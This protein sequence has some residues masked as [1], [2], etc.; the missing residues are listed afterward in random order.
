MNIDKAKLYFFSSL[1][2]FYTKNELASLYKFIFEHI[3]NTDFTQILAN[4]ELKINK[5]KLDKIITRLKNYEPYQYII[6]KTE[7][8]DLEFF[9]DK[10]VLIPRPE[11]EELV[12][13]IIDENKSAKQLNILDIGT[14]SGCI[15]VSLVKN[16]NCNFC[17]G[18]DV[19]NEAIKIAKQNAEQNSTQVNFINLNILTAEVKNFNTKFN[20]IVS[21]P[22]YVTD[23]QKKQMQKNVLNHEPHTALFVDDKNPL[24]FYEKIINLSKNILA[25][26]GILYLEINE[27]F[28]SEIKNLLTANKITNSKI[29]KDINNKN[30]IIIAKNN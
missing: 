4:T 8:F 14:G 15:I 2:D 26:N 12:K 24:I 27:N 6:G 5:N 11:T 21:N 13:L 7:F 3:L 16:L 18:V 20:I 10:N 30:R 1:S 25:E 23:S 22:P 9:V 19:S 29:V 17:L 28:A